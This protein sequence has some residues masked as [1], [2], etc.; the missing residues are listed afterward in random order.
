VVCLLLGWLVVVPP[1][2]AADGADDSAAPAAAL[3][4]QP[5]D[6]QEA[7]LRATEARLTGLR[8]TLTDREAYREALHTEL[9]RNDR[10]IAALARAV[11]GLAERHAD[12][13]ALVADLDE[14]LARARLDLAAVR[15]QLTALIRAAYA[16]GPGDRLRLLLNQQDPA[17]AGR[18]LGY[19][20]AV[21][22]LRAARMADVERLGRALAD[23]RRE[24]QREADRLAT[25]AAQERRTQAALQAASEARRAVLTE[26]EAAIADDRAE[27]A[28]LDANA[29]ALRE[30]VAELR[31]RAKI[32]DEI[33]ISEEAIHHRRGQLPPP[34]TD[35]RLVRRFAGKAR[36]GDLHADGVLFAVRV[37]SEVFP[38]HHGQVVY[39]DWL[40]GFGLLVVVDHGGGYMTLYGH[41]QALLKEVGEWVDPDDVLALS[42]TV[43]R[44]DIGGSGA[45]AAAG[46]L[47]FALRRDG[48]PVDPAPWLAADSS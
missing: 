9:E 36:P 32:A 14:R 10:D 12:Q 30:V 45:D 7:E 18:Q 1:A 48:A 17:R 47:Y 38:V 20:R 4:G 37:G 26:L 31:A 39:A 34:V 21:G 11:R 22:R 13:E 6:V 33:A 28:E 15:K 24:A 3:Q 44:T 35:A 42:G 29:A 25:L 23:L 16:V 2:A 46:R 19:F 8:E 27:V 43:S 5:L 40:R 41:N